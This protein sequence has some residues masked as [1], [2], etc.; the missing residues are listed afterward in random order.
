MKGLGIGFGLERIAWLA[1]DRPRLGLGALLVV[2]VLARRGGFCHA[3]DARK[4][5]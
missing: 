4:R 5:A 2:V 3:E 1:L